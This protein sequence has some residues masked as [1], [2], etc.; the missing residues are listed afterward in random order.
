MA[1]QQTDTDSEQEYDH[2]IVSFNELSNPSPGV[3][4]GGRG[5]P[6]NVTA[7]RKYSAPNERLWA[8]RVDGSD[9]HVIVINDGERYHN[10]VK[11]EP[12]ERTRVVP[13]EKLWAIP[14]N[15]VA[16]M[17]ISKDMIAY[18]RYFIPET[19]AWV[20]VSIPTNDYVADAGHS[21]Q[22]VGELEATP[23]TEVG[24]K[25]E[26]KQVLDERMK[27]AEG[28]WNLTGEELQA[29]REV[30]D[31]ILDNWDAI[32]EDHKRGCEAVLDDP[33]WLE[34]EDTLY[35]V[36]DGWVHEERHRLFHAE[37]AVR[38]V[39]DKWTDG[40]SAAL[41]EAI[42]ALRDADLLP[43]PYKVKIEVDESPVDADYYLSALVE[44]GCSPAE[45]MDYHAVEMVGRTQT[46]W[47]DIRGVGQST[48]SDNV[49]EAKRE[50][51]K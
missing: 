28:E 18:G 37:D 2:P 29:E 7:V 51:G 43:Y 22:A 30:C 32:E 5:Q 8:Y 13:G 17:K 36:G 25:Y 6:D 38:R 26:A 24:R 44:G 21:V 31:A 35:S 47:A 27:K 39:S 14:D 48:V 16:G 45:A 23:P 11:T 49:N 12:A 15:W 42:E 19:E 33:P 10:H 46:E 1:D 20:E 40:Q 3:S 34:R 4:R 50:I 9:E 41:S